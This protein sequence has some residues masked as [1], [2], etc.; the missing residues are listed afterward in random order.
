[1][2]DAFDT[3]GRQASPELEER[4]VYATDQSDSDFSGQDDDSHVS[5]DDLLLRYQRGDAASFEQLYAR[6]K[7]PVYRF[8]LRQLPPAQANDGFQETWTKLISNL[9]KFEARGVFQA[10]LFKLAHN[11]LMD[12][13]RKSMRPINQTTNAVET[14][15]IEA[16]GSDVAEQVS[17]AELRTLLYEQIAALPVNQRTVWLIKQETQ[18]NHSEIAE[19]TGTSLEGVKSRLRYANEKLKAGM[20]RYVRT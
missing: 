13:H 20:Q 3:A 7:G 9:D 17:R 8:F 12:H 15:D 5:D 2:T 14:E 4:S 10:Y 19:L 16:E 18:L 1:M 6:H 11:V